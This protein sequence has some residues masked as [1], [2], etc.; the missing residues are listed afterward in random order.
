MKRFAISTLVLLLSA[1]VAGPA[2]AQKGGKSPKTE[3]K[4]VQNYD[5]TGDDIDGDLVKP[6]GEF[7]D[8][9]NFGSHTKL[10]SIRKDFIQEILKSAEDI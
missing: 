10:I 1:A 7:I 6:D 3:E 2:F 8:T 5:F 4:K 9:R